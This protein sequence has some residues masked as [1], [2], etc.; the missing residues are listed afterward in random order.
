MKFSFGY[1]LYFLICLHYCF[2][3][4]HWSTI[5]SSRNSVR[6]TCSG[7]F[8]GVLP[9]PRTLL[10]F[11]SLSF[12]QDISEVIQN[13]IDDHCLCN[14]TV[15]TYQPTCICLIVDRCTL[16][17]LVHKYLLLFLSAALWIASRELVGIVSFVIVVLSSDVNSWSDLAV[18]VDI[19]FKRVAGG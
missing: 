9:A 13:V 15:S 7:C 4:A 14:I 5:Y 16:T 8:W 10:W 3:F 6:Q 12:W 19:L 17:Y 1:Y 11:V 18:D 2:L